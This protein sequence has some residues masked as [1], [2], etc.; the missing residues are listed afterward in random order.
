MLSNLFW[1]VPPAEFP[2]IEFGGNPHSK[3]TLLGDSVNRA[4]QP[5]KQ[6]SAKEWSLTLAMR[7]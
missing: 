1:C 7:S 6:S 3:R 2:R 4:H 5:P